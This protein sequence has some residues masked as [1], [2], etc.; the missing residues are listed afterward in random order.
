[1]VKQSSTTIS[2]SDELIMSRAQVKESSWMPLNGA[3]FTWKN[4]A[5][6]DAQKSHSESLENDV[7]RTN[8]KNSRDG[9]H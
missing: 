1:M 2:V 4:T 3:Q 7:H 6:L 9:G 5:A 8:R